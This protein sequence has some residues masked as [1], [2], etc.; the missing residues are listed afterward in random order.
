MSER[1]F[2]RGDNLRFI[3]TYLHENPGSR[4]TDIV[5]ALCEFRGKE[6]HRGM[7]TSYFRGDPGWRTW[8][9][10]GYGVTLWANHLGVWWLLPA[11]MEYV[12]V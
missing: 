4:Y 8:M 11:G 7:Y 2:R 3:A 6:Y 9:K 12:D 1:T 5:R 10:P